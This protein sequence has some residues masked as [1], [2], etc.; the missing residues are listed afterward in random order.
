MRIYGLK[1]CDT[2]RKALKW[3]KEKS[4]DLEFVDVR[5]GNMTR[6]DVSRFVTSAGWEKALNRKSTTW[7]S[8]DPADKTDVDDSKA[9]ELISQHPTLLK[10]PVFKM[11]DRIII[12]FDQDTQARLTNNGG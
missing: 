7:R 4:L 5:E 2:C 9:V 12:G 6:D 3:A 1:N 10:R 8:L 11:E